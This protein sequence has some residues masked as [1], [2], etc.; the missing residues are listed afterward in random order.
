MSEVTALLGFQSDLV[1]PIPET[2]QTVSEL[3]THSDTTSSVSIGEELSLEIR[4]Q[5]AELILKNRLRS[6]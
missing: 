1:V 6:Y 5:P 2:S 4:I 3:N